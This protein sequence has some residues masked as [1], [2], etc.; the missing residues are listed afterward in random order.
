MRNGR[1]LGGPQSAVHDGG[2]VPFF[3]G[4]GGRHLV[5]LSR[6]DFEPSTGRIV[7]NDVRDIE[8]DTGVEGC[9]PQRQRLLYEREERGRHERP[10]ETP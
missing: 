7:E 8:A 6:R 2:D 1:L 5:V 4:C 9:R 3:D 10:D